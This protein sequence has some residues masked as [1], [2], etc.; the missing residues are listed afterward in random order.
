MVLEREL[1]GGNLQHAAQ[2][3]EYAAYPDGITGANLAAAL[4][5]EATS[6]GATLEQ[7]EMAGL[8]LFSRSRW[9]ALNDGRGFSCT[10]V[11][12]AGGTR[13][14]RAGLANEDRLRGRGVIDCTPCDGGFFIG[15]PVA[16][17]G[18][19]SYALD[20]AE[21]LSKLGAQVTVLVPDGDAEAVRPELAGVDWRAGMRLDH[22]VGDER[23][24]AIVVSDRAAG[25]SETMP[26]RGVAIRLGMVPNSDELLDIVA[27]DPEGR[28]VVND[29][30]QTSAPFVLACGDLR[31]GS[32]SRV[33]S[34]IEDGR[35]AAEYAAALL[36]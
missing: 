30:Y 18:A 36:D 2:I 19:T 10:V 26:M 7:G 24:E 1:F 3:D 21:Y 13:F 27:S 17:Y 34:A 20:D 9:V 11:L 32:T 23:V 14:E 15:Q 31:S 12:L 5:D 4:I 22:I 28:I 33:G 25:T 8:E 35:R 6:A 29:R 16:I